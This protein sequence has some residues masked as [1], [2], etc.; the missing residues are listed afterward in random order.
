MNLTANTLC[1]GL[2]RLDGLLRFFTDDFEETHWRARPGGELHSAGWILAHL[3]HSLHEAAG[4]RPQ[5]E[6]LDGRFSYGAPAEV[7][8]AGP[9]LTELRQEWESGL[10]ALKAHWKARSPGE[11][12]EAVPP[13]PLQITNRAEAAMF[14]IQHASYH[15]G[16]LGAIRR[17]LGLP[18]RV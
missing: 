8:G 10:K 14:V 11:W 17:L 2:E 7:D 9:A 5:V 13:N 16:Q 4:S 12:A 1:S 15:I 6:A 3:A 18:G